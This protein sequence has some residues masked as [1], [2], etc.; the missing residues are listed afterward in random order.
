MSRPVNKARPVRRGASPAHG[1]SKDEAI[2]AILARSGGARERRAPPIGLAVP[3]EQL[4]ES[5]KYVDFARDER[6]ERAMNDLA[7]RQS[8]Q[9]G[10]KADSEANEYHSG[11]YRDKSGKLVADI[12]ERLGWDGGRP[13]HL[14]D[15][16]PE[17]GVHNHSETSARRKYA[18]IRQV[19]NQP[20]PTEE[21][22]QRYLRT[23]AREP[24]A[25]DA[26]NADFFGAGYTTY[27]RGPDGVLRGY[28][29]TSHRQWLP[30]GEL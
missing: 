13:S 23:E 6:E 14:R 29:R 12:F 5:P 16:E 7:R 1:L 17:G 3:Y 10:A 25:D 27:I 24:S 22:I 19:D 2:A 18:E 30:M 28:I 4:K 21:E 15:F 9:I 8:D 26:A 11:I 20:P